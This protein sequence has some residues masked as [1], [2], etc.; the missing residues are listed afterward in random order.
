MGRTRPKSRR[1]VRRRA[2]DASSSARPHGSVVVDAGVPATRDRRALLPGACLL[3]YVGQGLAA[4]AALLYLAGPVHLPVGSVGGCM[5]AA[6]FV[7]L[8]AAVPAGRACDRGRPQVVLAVALAAMAVA[9]AC[10]VVVRTVPEALGAACLYGSACQC[11]Y[12]ARAALAAA[13]EPDDPAG[14]NARLYRVGNIGYALATP[15]TG[16][17]ATS[18]SASAYRLALLGA[19]ATFALA[20]V[21]AILVRARRPAA[22]VAH[23]VPRSG[24]VQPWRDSRYLALTGLYAITAMQFCI[25]EFALPLWVVGH[26]SAPRAM[27]GASALISTFVVATLQP[28]ASRRAA[29]TRRAASAMAVAG[30]VAGIGCLALAVA[31]GRP[32]VTAAVLVGLGAVALAAAELCQAV[33]AI[34]LSYRLAPT[35]ATGTYQGFFSLGQGLTM[36]AGPAVLA[37]TVLRPGAGWP[38]AALLL[39]VAGLLVPAV[40]CPRPR[41]H[42]T[43]QPVTVEPGGNR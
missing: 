6:G 9:A 32:P 41:P 21:L 26:T 42:R 10:F 28:V 17:A 30:I 8:L 29:T 11:A 24:R 5:T 4:P 39:A 38:C 15:A 31:S 14:A 36:A 22:D 23:P 7:G 1:T 37:H 27:V 33:G 43:V 2:D 20:A 3:F 16:L 34:T 35:E 40:V 19:G 18:G 13:V 12:A 25:A